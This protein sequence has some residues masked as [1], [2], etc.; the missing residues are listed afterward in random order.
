M[1]Q[2]TKKK[3]R[4]KLIPKQEVLERA[5][6]SLMRIKKPDSQ[7]VKPKMKINLM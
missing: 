4:S 5:K 6:S 7:K 2:I 3:H 1:N